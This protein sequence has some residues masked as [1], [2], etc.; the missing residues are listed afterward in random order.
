MAGTNANNI[1]VSQ[2][3]ILLSTDGGLT[4]PTI[5]ATGVPNDGSQTVTVPDIKSPRCFIIVEAVGNFFFAMNTKSF[6]IG[7]FNEI[8][9]SYTADDAP[10]A[11][12][13]DNP[14]GVSSI[15]TVSDNVNVEKLK[16]SLINPPVNSRWTCDPGNYPY[17]LGDLSITLESPQGTVIEL[18]SN[19]CDASEDIEVVLSDDGDPLSCNVF[20]PGISGSI[21]PSAGIFSIQW[22]KCTGQLDIKSC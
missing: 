3:N 22:R 17:L 19:A 6:S 12:P 21:K 8:C 4:F 14:N 7:S 2:V 1:N 18:I 15:I 16:V 9:N 11:I 20:S 10:L 13:D 5:L